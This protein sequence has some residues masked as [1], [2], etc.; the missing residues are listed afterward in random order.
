MR[1]R[2]VTYGSR[3]VAQDNNVVYISPI[4]EFARAFATRTEALQGRGALYLV[5][6]LPSSSLTAD[7]DF[8]ETVSLSCTR[9]R[10]V[11]IEETNITMSDTESLTIVGPYMT[12]TDGRPV[13][14]DDGYMTRRRTG[15]MP[16]PKNYAAS[17]DG[18][19]SNPCPITAS[20]IECS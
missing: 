8:P 20:P 6:P 17:D 11:A 15:R 10:V 14:D 5:E 13:Y 19:Q 2:G 18:S 1:R 3:N 9:A 16:T 7:E 4:R 12:W